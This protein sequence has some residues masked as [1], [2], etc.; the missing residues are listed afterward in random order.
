MSSFWQWWQQIPS[1]MDPVI[2]GIGGFQLRW[3]GLMYIIA[4]ALTYILV[5]YRIKH[6]DFDYSQELIENFFMAAIIGVL[7]GG[8]L[9]YVL[10]Y[11]LGYYLRHPLEIIIPFSFS[12]GVQFTGISGISYHGGV[13]GVVL[14]FIYISRKY[15]VKFF[16]FTELIIPAIPLG[17]MFGRIGN[18]INGELYGRTTDVAWGMYFP[19][20]PTHQLR[21]PSQLYEAFVEGLLLFAIL[22]YFRKKTPFQGFL[23]GLYLA[24]YGVGRFFVEFYR[25]PDAHLGKVLGFMT[26]GQ[27]LCVAMVIGGAVVW[28]LAKQFQPAK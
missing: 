21:H 4:F 8:R 24:G 13:I 12:N 22:W 2:F 16:N 26:T 11:N 20:D 6:E 25:Q 7:V 18:F 1:H 17:Y 9:G 15:S 19:L 10:F 28:Y 23:P 5:K 3:Y 14:A 27:I